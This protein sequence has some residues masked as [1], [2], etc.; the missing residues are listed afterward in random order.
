MLNNKTFKSWW[1]LGLINF[2]VYSFTRNTNRAILL[3]ML[4]VQIIQQENIENLKIYFYSKYNYSHNLEVRW[5]DRVTDIIK[6]CES[7]TKIYK[8]VEK[9]M[10][11][12]CPI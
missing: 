3:R 9:G 12:L 7:K 5:G 1:S 8:K 6:L 2:H 10:E 4:L 11:M